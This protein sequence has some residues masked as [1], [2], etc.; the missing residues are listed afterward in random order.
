M[1]RSLFALVFSLFFLGTI[2]SVS[3]QTTNAPQ[4]MLTWQAH[5]SYIPPGYP[6]KAIPNFASTITASLALISAGKPIDLSGQTIYWY[7]NDTLIGGGLG[8]QNLTFTPFGGA[9]TFVT[10]KVELPAYNGNLLIHEVQIPV[11]QPKAVIEV[12]HPTAQFSVNP[13]TLLATP[14]FFDIA[15]PSALSY[16]W[17]VNGT[18]PSSAE[19]PESLIMN[20]G[21]NPQSGATFAVSLTITDPT[22][23][24][25]ANDSTELTY[26]KQL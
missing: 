3:A 17:S 14:Y 12:Q 4:F 19:N 8:V 23:Q 2:A 18:S 6:D 16:T 25:N 9:P 15:N 10:L 1:L 22:T 11:V 13:I 21:P 24:M 7:Q 5:N 26:V 20:V